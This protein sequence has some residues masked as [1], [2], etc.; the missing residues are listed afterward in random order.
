MVSQPLPRGKQTPTI[1]QRRII[2]SFAMDAASLI[3]PFQR[4][5]VDAFSEL[6]RRARRSFLNLRPEPIKQTDPAD[7]EF[8]AAIRQSMHV[9]DWIPTRLEPAY[10]GAYI[11]T[12]EATAQTVRLNMGLAINLPDAVGRRIVREG[13]R[14]LGL[15][16]IQGQAR[17][18]LFH[19]IGEGRAMGLA[20]EDLARHIQGRI[21][22]GPWRSVETRGL[23]IARTETLNA[24]RMS[25]LEV[26]KRTDVVDGVQAWDAQIGATDAECEERDGRVFSFNDADGET[27]FEHPNGTL[28]WAPHVGR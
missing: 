23:V 19:A 22:R 25:A 8:V 3:P 10:Q 7:A 15:V 4:D 21:T 26:Y 28:S 12:L 16:D 9:A 6:G 18:S 2:R 13:G 1:L 24:Q 20:R 17:R 14:R 27:A 11:R 5:L